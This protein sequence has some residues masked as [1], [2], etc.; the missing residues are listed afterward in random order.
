MKS[1]VS[2]FKPERPP[3]FYFANSAS[4]LKFHVQ[5]D[6]GPAKDNKSSRALQNIT[7]TVIK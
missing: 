5:K 2:Y 4:L 6:I 1:T 3:D 7:S